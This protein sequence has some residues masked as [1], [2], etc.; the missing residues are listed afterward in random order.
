MWKEFL[1]SVE[2]TNVVQWISCAWY[3]SLVLRYVYEKE[4]IQV[5]VD[6]PKAEF[7]TYHF[8]KTVKD[9]VEVFPNIARILD[10]MLKKIDPSNPILVAYLQTINPLVQTGILFQETN[11]G[12]SKK[13]KK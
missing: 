11:E 1:K 6:E 13:S 10:S 5:P 12:S 7:L 2:N 4:G 9:D 8:L 3:W